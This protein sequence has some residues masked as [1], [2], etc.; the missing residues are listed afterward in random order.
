MVN[1]GPVDVAVTWG[2]LTAYVDGLRRV[3]HLDPVVAAELVG[4]LG[5]EPDQLRPQAV[6]SIITVRSDDPVDFGDTG[7]LVLAD[8]QM[9]AVSPEVP[10][11]VP[12]GYHRFYSAE[13]TTPMTVVGSPAVA[14]PCP[15]HGWGLSVQPY[16]LRSG[17]D[18]GMG[19]LGT[20][21]QLA[22]W[23]ARNGA[24]TLSLGPMLAAAPTTPREPSPYYPATRLFID[25][26]YLSM[27][28]VRAPDGTSVGVPRPAHLGTGAD[29]LI[30]RDAVHAAKYSAL[31]AVWTDVERVSD[32]L[33]QEFLATSALPVQLFATWCVL[34]EEFG[35][36]WRRWPPEYHAPRS[37]KVEAFAEQHAGEVRFHVWLQWMCEQQVAD[38]A[39]EIDIINDLPVGFD[40]GG[41]DGWLW[42]KALVHQVRIGAP[43]DGFAPEGH[44]WDAAP[45][46]PVAL[47]KLR[48]APLVAVWRANMGR[49]AGL[50]LDHAMHLARLFWV[51]WDR[52]PA[53][54]A[55]VEYPFQ[56]ILDLLVLESA[57]NN[58]FVVTEDL[59]NVPTDFREQIA[60]RGLLRTIILWFVKQPPERWPA[61]AV[62]CVSNHDHPPVATVWANRDAGARLIEVDPQSEEAFARLSHHQ[63]LVALGG[64]TPVDADLLTALRRTHTGL[65]HSGARLVLTQVLDLM[66]GTQQANSPTGERSQSWRVPL[67][68]L[69]EDLLKDEVARELCALLAA[70]RHEH[71]SDDNPTKGQL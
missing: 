10:T 23:A 61:A 41:F 52:T 33:L 57:T 14:A 7:E 30:D 47:E 59:G 48:F 46:S 8:G 67:P 4:H 26:L 3:R 5:G 15:R 66:R 37:P 55:Y 60:D 54:G 20:I 35:G 71:Q 16:A 45:F 63:R 13:S 32:H 19:D 68:M 65:G 38:L 11:T 58:C 39:E 6:A 9:V 29:A 53:E 24:T 1:P 49:G 40:P 50:H 27:Q 34:V 2:V 28:D 31:R 36:D 17:Q 42:Q 12:V 70:A 43:P 51:P 64:G 21:I 69:L 62:A 44:G 18:W 22:R 56:E 25:P